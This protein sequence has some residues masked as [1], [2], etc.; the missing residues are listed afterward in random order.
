MP[1]PMRKRNPRAAMVS[2]ISKCID[3]VLKEHAVTETS[4]IVLNENF[5]IQV[6]MDT[7]DEILRAIDK[8]GEKNAGE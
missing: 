8:K 3:K 6:A 2:L 4:K 1:Y 7:C 5:R